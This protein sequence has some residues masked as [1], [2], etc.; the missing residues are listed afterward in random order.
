MPSPGARDLGAGPGT[1]RVSPEPGPAPLTTHPLPEGRVA[2][3]PGAWLGEGP[4]PG[5]WGRAGRAG[6]GQACPPPVLHPLHTP[7]ALSLCGEGAGQ[8]ACGRLLLL[9]RGGGIGKA[10]GAGS[11]RPASIYKG[12]NYQSSQDQEWRTG[13]GGVL[14]HGGG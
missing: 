13:G 8:P 11:G 9:G 14:S 7:F 3:T 6:P 4:H 2:A 1:S 10:R 12:R 5:Q